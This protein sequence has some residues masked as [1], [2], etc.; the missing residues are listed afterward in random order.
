MKSFETWPVGPASRS[1]GRITPGDR[2]LSRHRCCG[3]CL[4]ALGLA[5]RHQPRIVVQPPPADASAAAWPICRHWS[6]PWP[7][8][9]PGWML[10]AMRRSRRN[11]C[12]SAVRHGR[13]RCCRRGDGCASRRSPKSAI[14]GCASKTGK[15]CWRFRRRGAVRSRMSFPMPDCGV[16]RRSF[17]A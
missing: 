7:A 4:A 8:V 9:R 6:P 12:W 17:M 14:T 15:L 11:W 10:A 3:A 1:N 13:S 5:G 16:W 2:T